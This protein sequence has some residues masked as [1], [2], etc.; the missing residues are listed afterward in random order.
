[1]GLFGKRKI[2]NNEK[3]RELNELL[4]LALEIDQS[5]GTWHVLPENLPSETHDLIIGARK[6][7]FEYIRQLKEAGV[8]G[9]GAV[10]KF[11]RELY[12]WIS[13][14]NVSKFIKLGQFL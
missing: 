4:D 9:N 8:Y 12:P 13:K 10:N 5:T 2:V 1:M 3:N 14:Q 7:V 6:K 11:A